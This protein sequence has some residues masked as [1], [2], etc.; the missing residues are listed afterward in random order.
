[1]K[2]NRR[3]LASAKAAAQDLTQR[4]AWVRAPRR[5]PVLVRAAEPAPQLQQATR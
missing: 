5:M 1:M 3:W 4:L 2:P